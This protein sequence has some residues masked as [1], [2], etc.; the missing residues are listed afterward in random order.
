M[1][2]EWFPK[3]EPK[4][5]VFVGGASM[6]ENVR[7]DDLHRGGIVT[8]SIETF[9]KWNDISFGDGCLSKDPKDLVR[10]YEAEVDDSNETL[11]PKKKYTTM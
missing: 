1:F 10:G 11:E 7:F 9:N 6:L 5:G 3:I 2:A 8:P 4:I